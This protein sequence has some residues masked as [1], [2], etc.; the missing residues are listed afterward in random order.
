MDAKI[1]AMIDAKIQSMMASGNEPSRPRSIPSQK[2]PI[3]EASRSIPEEVPI[4]DKAVLEHV[5]DDDDDDEAAVDKAVLEA[6]AAAHDGHTVQHV[7]V[8]LISF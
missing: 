1:H 3:P 4:F 8:N 7:H 5:D 6:A 2:R